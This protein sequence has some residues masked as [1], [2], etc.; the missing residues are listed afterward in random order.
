M[1]KLLPERIP[2]ESFRP[3]DVREKVSFFE[4]PNGRIIYGIQPIY[5]YGLVINPGECEEYTPRAYR[6]I[7]AVS[8]SPLLFAT[9]NVSEFVANA[10]RDYDNE[11]DYNEV[12]SHTELYLLEPQG[13]I[14]VLGKIESPPSKINCNN[15]DGGVSFEVSYEKLENREGYEDKYAMVTYYK[16]YEVFYQE[17]QDYVE[18]IIKRQEGDILSYDNQHAFRY[19]FDGAIERITP[20]AISRIKSPKQ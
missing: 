4:L 12:Y 13:I 7:D 3:S 2:R 20:S 11:Q 10:A 19:Y 17:G 18:V 5:S 6:T 1:K 15:I 16:T 8:G 9:K 14:I